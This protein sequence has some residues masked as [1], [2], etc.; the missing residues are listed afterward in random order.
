MPGQLAELLLQHGLVSA[1]PSSDGS[2]PCRRPRPGRRAGRGFSA[3]PRRDRSGATTALV[4]ALCLLRL[5][6]GVTVRLALA[7]LGAQWCLG[8]ADDPYR[9][10][11]WIEAGGPGDLA[12]RG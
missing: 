11:A 6:F 12:V 9:F 4:V 3:A 5:P 2:E 10:H 8:S 1:E 7:G